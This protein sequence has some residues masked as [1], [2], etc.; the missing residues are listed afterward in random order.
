MTQTMSMVAMSMKAKDWFQA[1]IRYGLEGSMQVLENVF[2]SW[3][4]ANNVD[5]NVL[6]RHGSSP[7]L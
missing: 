4:S 2:K 7:W 1:W 5:L 6:G 3:I